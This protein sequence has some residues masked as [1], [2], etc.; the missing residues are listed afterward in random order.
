MKSLRADQGRSTLAECASSQIG[1]GV[2]LSCSRGGP[3]KMIVLGTAGSRG[4]DAMV[5]RERVYTVVMPAPQSKRWFSVIRGLD[6]GMRGT[7]KRLHMLLHYAFTCVVVSS[8][9]VTG[10]YAQTQGQA[11][12]FESKIRPIFAEKCSVCHGEEMQMAELQLTT[13]KGFFKGANSG[14]VVVPRGPSRQPA[15]PGRQLPGK[16]QDASDREAVGRADRGAYRVGPDGGA[17]AQRGVG[18]SSGLGPCKE[19]RAGPEP[20]RTLG[21]SAGQE[22]RTTA[23]RKQGLGSESHRQFHPGETRRKGLKP[24]PAAN[25]L[26]LLRRVKFDLHGLPPTEPEIEE[27]LSDTAKGAFARLIDRLLAS[28]RYGERWGRHWLDVARYADSTG[29]DEDLP[30]P[31]SWRYRDYVIEA[32][33][34]DLPYDQFIREQIA[35]DLIPAEKP[36]EVNVQGIVATGFLALGPRAVAQI[37]KMRLTYDV[38]DEQIDTLSKTFMGLTVACARC[39]DH[40]FDPIT[41]KDYY[42]LVSI[43]ASTRN[44]ENIKPPGTVVSKLH[45]EPLVPKEVYQNY[46]DHQ[47]KIKEKGLEI[48]AIEEMEVAR[49]AAQRL[50]PRLPN[51]MVAAWNVYQEGSTLGDTAR[52]EGLDEKILEHG[53]II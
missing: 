12:F 28:P 38:I 34:R 5:G 47:E 10:A 48:E 22:S 39:H 31:S 2:P 23:G 52:Q 19:G 6:G 1:M 32:F 13:E 49:D 20:D 25:R 21:V 41:T 42:S 27:F 36:G 40:K 9:A 18:K 15:H 4:S 50:Y 24:A 29:L 17:L 43:F 26:T 7:V 16:N 3:A 53:S 51:Y 37:D 44:F 11:E 35:G 30:Y 14:P 33:N 45:F 46:K 8:I